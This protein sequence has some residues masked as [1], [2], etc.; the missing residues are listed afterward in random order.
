[1]RITAAIIPGLVLSEYLAGYCALYEKGTVQTV[2]LFAAVRLYFSYVLAALLLGFLSIGVF[3]L[4]VLSGIY[5][6]MTMFAVAC[7]I[8]VYGVRA[9]L[10]LCGVR[11]A[12]TVYNPLLFVGGCLCLGGIFCVGNQ[13]AGEAMCACRL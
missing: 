3:A 11:T 10:W 12:S 6:F 5:G 8:Q 4:P 7:F 9:V 13:V 2:S 1:M